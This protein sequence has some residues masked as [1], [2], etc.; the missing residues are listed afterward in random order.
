MHRPKQISKGDSMTLEELAG[1]PEGARISFVE[2][3]QVIQDEII[4]TLSYG[5]VV[6]SGRSIRI[7]W[8]TSDPERGIPCTTLIDTNSK[9]WAKFVAD[10]EK[11]VS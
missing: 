8:D 10:I 7:D 4:R 6:Q 2:D 5:T 9:S 3:E 1:L 11:V